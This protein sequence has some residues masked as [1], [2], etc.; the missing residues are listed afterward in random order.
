MRRPGKG[1]ELYGEGA[2]RMASMRDSGA[3]YFRD[4][5]AQTS[6]AVAVL[7]RKKL[8]PSVDAAVEYVN[9]RSGWAEVERLKGAISTLELDLREAQAAHREVREQLKM[10]QDQHRRSQ[11]EMDTLLVTKH[12][13]S[14]HQLHQYKKLLEEERNNSAAMQALEAAYGNTEHKVDRSLNSLME[15]LRKRFHEEQLWT[16]RIRQLS[17][18]ST[19]AILM[20]N[21][22]IFMFSYLLRWREV[23]NV[24]TAVKQIREDVKKQD[25]AS[26]SMCAQVEEMNQHLQHMEHLLDRNQHRWRA[27]SS[28]AA[29]AA[30]DPEAWEDGQGGL[31][32]K[33]K[34]TLA[35]WFAG[36]TM[37]A[38]WVIGRHT[39]SA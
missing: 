5:Y 29:R 28:S 4:K 31:S 36:T 10:L 1:E 15:G 22:L 37:L 16:D 32:R 21:S 17:T 20:A 7:I 14:E 30:P 24:R 27:H 35:V 9:E 23:N 33:Q 38:V 13:W 8:Q 3:L 18:W 12:M 34:T 19:I 11:V 26:K 25:L 2:A 6:K 39:V